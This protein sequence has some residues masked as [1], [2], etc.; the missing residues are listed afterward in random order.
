MHV[1]CTQCNVTSNLRHLS[2]FGSKLHI[3]LD[4][5]QYWKWNIS[6]S[7]INVNYGMLKEYCGGWI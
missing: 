2:M 6:I 7:V 1:C 5:F 3:I 4:I